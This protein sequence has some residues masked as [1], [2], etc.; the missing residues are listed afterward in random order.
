MSVWK[1]VLWRCG[2]FRASGRGSA[3]SG[4]AKRRSA[5]AYHACLIFS[6]YECT[7]LRWCMF[8][9]HRLA[10]PQFGHGQSAGT[11]PVIRTLTMFRISVPELLPDVTRFVL[12]SYCHQVHISVLSS[13][14]HWSVLF[15]F[16]F[17]LKRFVCAVDRT[18]CLSAFGPAR[19]LFHVALPFAKRSW[20]DVATSAL[21]N[22]C[23]NVCFLL[24]NDAKNFLFLLGRP[25][26]GGARWSTW[27]FSVPQ[28]YTDCC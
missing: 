2:L 15:D 7:P 4:I 23:Q 28:R 8:R 5:S 3:P 17:I 11:R 24:V 22:C 26:L 1:A 20:F 16:F 21:M 19:S 12:F 10:Q 9:L 25:P 27:H 14:S 13:P 6:L 18:S